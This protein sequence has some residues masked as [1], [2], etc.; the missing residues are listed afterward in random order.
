MKISRSVHFAAL[1][2][3]IGVGVSVTGA[4][5]AADQKEQ[6]VQLS[7]AGQSC[8]QLGVR[9]PQGGGTWTLYYYTAS[10]NSITVERVMQQALTPSGTA[11]SYTATYFHNPAGYAA[12]LINGTP[13][14][15]NGNFGSTYWA[16]CVNGKA[17][18]LGMSAQTV[19]NGDKV[20]WTY[21]AYPPNCN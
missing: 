18:D 5:V 1:V 13:A 20:L 7:C 6:G 9:Q 16:L 19:K 14:T 12:M 4:S 10:A 17:A 15:T 8:I 21:T 11:L 2:A 3:V